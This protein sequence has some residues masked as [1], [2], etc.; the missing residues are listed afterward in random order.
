MA[1]EPEHPIR[2]AAVGVLGGT[3]RSV[4]RPPADPATI[5]LPPALAA[6]VLELDAVVDGWFDR[7]RGNPAADRLFYGAS[8]VGDFSLVWHIVGVTR[9]LGGRRQEQEAARLGVSLG[10]ESVLINGLVKSLF[11]RT[12]PVRQQH[13]ARKLRNPKSSSFP[14]GHA[15]SGFMAATLLGAGRSKRTKAL[16]YGAAAIVAASRV[17]VKIHHPS[18]VL[19][20]AVVGVGLGAAAKRIWPV[21]NARVA[22]RH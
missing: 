14:S 8:A 9:A 13:S 2:D 22:P 16:W 21:G 11:R 7:L 3:P 19:A 20:G 17:H 18:D 1:A 12:R 5:V 10:I 15:T 6:K 4:E